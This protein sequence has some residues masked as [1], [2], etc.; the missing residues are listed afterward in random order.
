MFLIKF[1][2]VDQ[3]VIDQIKETNRHSEIQATVRFK[4]LSDLL[5]G[6]QGRFRQNLLGNTGRLLRTFRY[7]GRTGTENAP[8]R[9][10]K[11]NGT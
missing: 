10:S 8:M 4:S 5:K 11:G 7:R 3:Q 1:D 6:K 2:L 9:S